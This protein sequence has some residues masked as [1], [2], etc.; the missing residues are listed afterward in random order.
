MICWMNANLN[1]LTILMSARK[2]VFDMLA[3]WCYKA[4]SLDE[5]IEQVK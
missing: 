4:N 3:K 2:N 1:F 5:Q